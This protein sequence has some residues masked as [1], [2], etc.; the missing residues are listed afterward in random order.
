[1]VPGTKGF[2][3]TACQKKKEEEEGEGEKERIVFGFPK[4]EM[5]AKLF[6]FS[7]SSSFSLSVFLKKESQIP[8]FG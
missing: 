4:K 1:M 6:S 7:L 5:F 2:R 3:L 8:R